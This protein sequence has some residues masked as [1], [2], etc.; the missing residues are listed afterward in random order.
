MKYQIDIDDIVDFIDNK[1]SYPIGEVLFDLCFDCDDHIEENDYLDEFDNAIESIELSHKIN[2]TRT[3]ENSEDTSRDLLIVNTYRSA[4]ES[5]LYNNLK[6]SLESLDNFQHFIDDKGQKCEFW[7]STAVQF[8]ITCK[9]I[10]LDKYIN[11]PCREDLAYSGYTRGEYL[12]EEYLTD[13]TPK[14]SHEDIYGYNGIYIYGSD[15]EKE[16]IYLMLDY[17]MPEYN[18]NKKQYFK[19]LKALIKNKIPMIYRNKDNVLNEY[20]ALLFA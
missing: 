13:N 14:L 17:A 11:E 16:L 6:S 9:D 4:Y 18:Y 20:R 1:N 8:N 2:L 5:E 19:R 12:L 7:E 15:F 3:I 10:L